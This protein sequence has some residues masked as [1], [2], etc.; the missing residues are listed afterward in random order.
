MIC[1]WSAI[2]KANWEATKTLFS[3]SVSGNKHLKKHELGLLPKKYTDWKVN[4]RST[5]VQQWFQ[6]DV[7]PCKAK[8]IF[9]NDAPCFRHI[10]FTNKVWFAIQIFAPNITTTFL[11]LSLVCEQIYF[12]IFTQKLIQL[13]KK[14]ENLKMRYIGIHLGKNPATYPKI[15]FKK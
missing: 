10:T 13:G 12:W 7:T 15:H 1:P 11:W 9:E 6:F 4:N 2:G 3:C 5:S 14:I 8:N